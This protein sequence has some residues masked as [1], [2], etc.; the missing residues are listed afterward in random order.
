MKLTIAA[1][2]GLLSASAFAAPVEERA[3]AAATTQWT[4]QNM[5]RVCNDADTSCTYSFSIN[6]HGATPVTPCKFT[7]HGASASEQQTFNHACGVFSVGTGWNSQGFVVMPTL[8][9]AKG[10]QAYPSYSD[11]E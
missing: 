1:L 5:K 3:D 4:I 2:A 10:L 8:W 9:S 6:T 11:A 7:I